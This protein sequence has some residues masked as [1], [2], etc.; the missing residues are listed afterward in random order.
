MTDFVAL[1]SVVT[2][3][4]VGLGGIGASVWGA[5][6]ER[7]WK[8]HE[9]RVTELRSVLDTAAANLAGAKKQ[10]MPSESST[11]RRRQS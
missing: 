11:M 2:S 5:S 10:S 8:S 4:M 9:E 6:R 7:R 1:A 3:G